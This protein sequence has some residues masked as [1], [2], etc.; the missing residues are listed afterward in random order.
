MRNFSTVLAG[1]IQGRIWMPACTCTKDFSLGR[2][3]INWADGHRSTLRELADRA[4]N[5]GDFR[6]A[7]L[8]PDC[9]VTV[10]MVK[11]VGSTTITRRKHF[12][13]TMFPSIADMVAEEHEF[14]C[15]EED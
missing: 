8:S 3:D 14:A 10:K 1:Q 13:V 2:T 9:Y 7:E 15:S 4:T 5:D 12:P 6:S 11:Q